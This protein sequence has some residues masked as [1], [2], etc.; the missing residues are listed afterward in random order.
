MVAC[1]SDRTRLDI[2]TTCTNRRA[3][4]PAFEQWD[5]HTATILQGQSVGGKLLSRRPT[6][7]SPMLKK[8]N[9]PLIYDLGR[10]VR[11]PSTFFL[12]PLCLSLSIFRF[13]I[14]SFFLLA[15][16]DGH[17]ARPRGISNTRGSSKIFGPYTLSYSI[18]HRLF[19]ARPSNFS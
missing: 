15:L 8:D 17:L 9:R 11:S 5:H 3:R 13:A 1:I 4:G 19:E 16:L 10:L 14:V 12:S 7:R 18:G 6:V 2:H